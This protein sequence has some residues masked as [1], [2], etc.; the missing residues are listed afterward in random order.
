VHAVSYWADEP[1]FHSADPR[2]R[3]SSEVDLGATW[4]RAGSNDAWRV[5]WIRDTGEL[6]VCRADGYDGSCS[7][8]QVLALVPT[9]DLVDTLL[10][11]WQDQ[12]TDPDGLSWLAARAQRVPLAA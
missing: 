2:R 7:D 12:R 4:R 6:Y 9:E 5:S 11:G 3:T 10:A 1:A 8:V